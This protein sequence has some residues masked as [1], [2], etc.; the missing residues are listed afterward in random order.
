MPGRCALWQGPARSF[1]SL[2]SQ[3]CNRASSPRVF[4]GPGVRA[5]TRYR[6]LRPRSPGFGMTIRGRS[7]PR[8]GASAHLSQVFRRRTVEDARSKFA[9]GVLTS[10]FGWHDPVSCVGRTLAQRVAAVG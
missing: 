8:F 3:R 9:G 1:V 5:D 2:T 10:H 6:G 7:G 4:P